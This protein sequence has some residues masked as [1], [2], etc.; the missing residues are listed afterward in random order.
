MKHGFGGG[1]EIGLEQDRGWLHQPVPRQHGR[2]SPMRRKLSGREP[3]GHL[4]P[5]HETRL[6]LGI[7][8]V[9]IARTVARQQPSV[10]ETRQGISN[11]TNA[12]R[13]GAYGSSVSH[14]G[15]QYETSLRV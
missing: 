12:L 2:G 4:A 3:M 14:P 5:E 8:D 1:S 13:S 9:D 11:A 15:P 10:F 7:A 6:R